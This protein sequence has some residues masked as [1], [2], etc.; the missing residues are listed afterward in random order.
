MS[1]V[2]QTL[3]LRGKLQEAVQAPIQH[4]ST[5]VP[6][7]ELGLSWKWAEI[8][9]SSVFQEGGRVQIGG[10]NAFPRDGNAALPLQPV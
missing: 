6:L 3:V 5:I 7:L 4:S 2:Q 10:T 9:G 8:W 1:A